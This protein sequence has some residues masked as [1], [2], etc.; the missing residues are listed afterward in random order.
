MKGFGLG[1]VK[2]LVGGFTRNIAQEE[3]V[4][5][6]DDQRVADLEDTIIKASLDPKK[7]VPES[8]GNMLK[9][10][11]TQLEQRGSIGPFGMAGPRLRLD[12]DQVATSLGAIDD[13]QIKI[14]TYAFP[15]TDA[16]F[17]SSIQK[18]GYARSTQFWTSLQNHL[19]KDPT[20]II[21]FRK[22]FQDNPNESIFL[23][24]I[25]KKNQR[26]LLQGYSLSQ[27]PKGKMGEQKSLV[28]T[29]LLREFKGLEPIID[30]FDN[31]TSTDG[32]T[33]A[34]NN[35][36][37][38]FNKDNDL[39]ANNMFK[40]SNLYIPYQ[41]DGKLMAFAY[42]PEDKK[43]RAIFDS[44]AE[45]YGYK[46]KTNQ[47]LF[48]Y[49]TRF[50]PNKLY[51]GNISLEDEDT[52][53][54]NAYGYLFHAVELRKLNVNN[55]INIDKPKVMNYLNESFGQGEKS[56]RKKVLAL[57][58]AMAKPTKPGSA[59]EAN[60]VLTMGQPR[61]EELL[62]IIG[63][64]KKDFEEGYNAAIKAR[65]QLEE[66]LKLRLKI[67]TSDG[68]VEEMYKLGYG[69]FGTGGQVSQLASMLSSR[70]DDDAALFES[71][72][73]KV[74][75][76]SNI[77]E[78]GKIE[79]LKIELAF[80]LARAADPSGR[81]SNQ[82]FEVQLRRL[83]TT[84]IFTNIP[85]QISAIE[86]VLADT[87]N[88]VDQ[89]SLI[90]AIYNKASTGKFNTLSDAERR[91]VYASKQFH[92]LRRETEKVGAALSRAEFLGN[93]D[94]KNEAGNPKYIPDTNNPD[95]VIDTDTYESIPR[96]HIRDG[97]KI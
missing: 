96:S 23:N 72:L 45:D 57:S 65:N 94:D 84:G 27:S 21:K 24:S 75:K 48:N 60:D 61:Q 4:R 11:K 54:K 97:D 34:I 71:T 12:M 50:S 92:Q 64:K 42:T 39:T 2:G 36:F 70:S 43:E 9:D 63:V 37:K 29:T 14:G 28:R 73:R 19:M 81:L 44:L 46:G 87:Q 32:E 41:K 58:I 67:E 74:F 90:Y 8:L 89:R 15:G 56:D 91:I 66:L 33:E 5:G 35:A 52:N 7:R 47:F 62:S 31:D 83:G 26:D 95:N 17:E 49:A 16:Y 59:M 3:Q 25:F 86:T 10:A 1:L 77:D 85:S 30:L 6:L 82:D 80:T 78:L 68:L 53:I 51:E 40:K 38:K 93:K 79:A 20:N 88:L 13:N 18:D 55:L 69:L 76:K 22:H